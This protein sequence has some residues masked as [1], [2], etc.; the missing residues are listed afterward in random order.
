M[1]ERVLM[2]GR[3]AP[4]ERS[5]ENDFV[6]YGDRRVYVYIHCTSLGKFTHSGI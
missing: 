4:Q 6:S 2:K 3:R 1:T 5:E